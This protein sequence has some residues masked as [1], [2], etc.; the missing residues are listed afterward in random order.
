VSAGDP[1]VIL[2]RIDIIPV[3]EEVFRYLGYP[4]GA[5]PGAR[6]RAAVDDAV[7]RSPFHPRGMYRVHAIE[8]QD[9]STLV[10]SNGIVITGAIGDFLSGAVR[11]AA[12]V[13]T[14][15]AE[16]EEPPG[17]IQGKKEALPGLVLHALGAHL[18]D[19]A[20]GRL[21]EVLRSGAKPGETLTLPYSPGYCGIPIV[22]QQQIF[23]LF[24]ASRLGVELL[25][26]MVMRPLK[27]VSGLIGIGPA[28]SITAY[29]NPCDAC[30]MIDCAMRRVS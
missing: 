29:G 22:Q 7:R 2:D 9:R 21:A 17:N 12:F 19:A 8:R 16:P 18:A 30:P 6:V 15:G 13:A 23:R 20:V 4:A 10:L 5:D 3:P 25:P 1:T 27:S 28:E 24:D 11:A 26:S 14:A